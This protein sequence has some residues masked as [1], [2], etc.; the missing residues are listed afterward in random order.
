MSY[1]DSLVGIQNYPNA[2]PVKGKQVVHVIMPCKPILHAST[3]PVASQPPRRMPPV[4][5]WTKLTVDGSFC[6]NS[7]MAGAGMIL[8]DS[9][10]KIIFFL[11][12]SCG[13]VFSHWRPS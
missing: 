3:A 2:N 13:R 7:G 10:G 5:G 4:E 11:A 12:G 9:P 6:A 1:V 8:R